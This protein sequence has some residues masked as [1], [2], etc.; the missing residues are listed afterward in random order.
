MTNHFAIYKASTIKPGTSSVVF[1]DGDDYESHT[2]IYIYIACLQI[3]NYSTGSSSNELVDLACGTQ[4]ND[5]Y[6]YVLHD[7]Y[8][9][10]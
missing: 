10:R 5:G 1:T 3:F 2:H 7:S 9:F 8:D 6:F 4:I